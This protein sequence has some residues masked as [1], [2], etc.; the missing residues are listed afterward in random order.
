MPAKTGV[1]AKGF[2][3][4]PHPVGCVGGAR[5]VHILGVWEHWRALCGVVTDGEID[6]VG[7]RPRPVCALCRRAAEA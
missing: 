1:D 4:Y 2:G 6:S 3:I 7:A 5:K